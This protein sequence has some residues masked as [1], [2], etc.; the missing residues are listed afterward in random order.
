MMARVAA[1]MDLPKI[2]GATAISALKQALADEDYTVRMLAWD[3]LVEVF[4]LRRHTL[5][6]EGIPEL[7]THLEHLH[8][9]LGS[10]I[11]AFVRIGVAEM[12]ALMDRL[13]AGATPESL[14]IAWAPNPAPEVF[15]RLR[16]ALFDPEATFPVD[17]LAQLT[18]NARHLA[19]MIIAQ[20]LEKQDPRVPAALVR[21]AASWTAPGLEEVARSAEISP[22]LREQL[23]QAAHVLQTA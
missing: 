11:A 1:V 2:G 5:S 22:E 20:R 13:A 12:R 18:G 15:T 21:L 23:T 10:S 3:G 6:P 16:L 4:D 9:L 19:E 17:E 14:G 8:V 7:S